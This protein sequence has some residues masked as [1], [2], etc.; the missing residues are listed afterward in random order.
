MVS[1]TKNKVKRKKRNINLTVVK[2]EYA[3]VPDTEERLKRVFKIFVRYLGREA[4]LNRYSI[5]ISP[6]HN[7]PMSGASHAYVAF[8]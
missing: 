8:S 6:R 3:Q 2:V 4:E 1:K 5:S 7:E